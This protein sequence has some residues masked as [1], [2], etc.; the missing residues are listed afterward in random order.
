MSV[1][2]NLGRVGLVPRG[3]YDAKASYRRLDVVTRE[4]SA[5]VA[6][7][8]A[9]GIAPG[10]D[11]EVPVWQLLAKK[12]DKGDAGPVGPQGPQ[13]EPGRVEGIPFSDGDPAALGEASPGVSGGIS[14]ADHVHPMPTAQEVGARPDSWMPTAQEVGARPDS[15]TPTATE[16]GA[17]AADIPKAELR[18]AAGLT[19][20][21]AGTVLTITVTDDPDELD[22]Q[23]PVQAAN[24]LGGEAGGIADAGTDKGA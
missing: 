19:F 9:Q 7:C 4:G 6:L 16:V 22:E 23:E 15:W 20:S 11:G 10:A 12:G 21:L 2:T 8:D 13:G 18:A 3:E 5:Y 14:R 1:K 24:G 17:I